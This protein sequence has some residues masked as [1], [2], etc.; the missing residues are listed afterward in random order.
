MLR[1]PAITTVSLSG[2]RWSL[3]NSAIFCSCRATDGDSAVAAGVVV[4]LHVRADHVERSARRRDLGVG[5]SFV[6][7]RVRAAPVAVHVL[8]PLLDGPA[9]EDGDTAVLGLRAVVAAFRGVPPFARPAEHRGALREGVGEVAEQRVRRC[10]VERF[11]QHDHVLV[12][13]DAF[14]VDEVG[15]LLLPQCV[16]RD[17]ASMNTL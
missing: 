1:S 17:V 8:D 2:M 5:E 4:R 9:G 16:Y 14:G 11:L 7:E 6:G 10:V 13:E 15:A 3:T 12:G